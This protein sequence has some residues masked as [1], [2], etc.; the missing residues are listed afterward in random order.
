MLPPRPSEIQNVLIEETPQI[1]THLP[2]ELPQKQLFNGDWVY[3]LG[4]EL[5]DARY[6]AKVLSVKFNETDGET[7]EALKILDE[8][9]PGKHKEA[10]VVPPFYCDYG[11]NIKL[12]RRA[13]L[14]VNTVM[15]DGALISIGDYTKV[16]PNC[17]F[18]TPE[19]PKDPMGR[20]TGLER[21]RPIIIG[22]DVWV[23][24]NV[25]FCPGVTV[26]DNCII[27]AGSVVTRSI[28][29]NTIAVGNP[30]KVL[31]RLYSDGDATVSELVR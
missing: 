26:G 18:N 2:P 29:A 1:K 28:P 12:G 20:R 11:C 23:G 14:N 19:H 9:L 15:L 30:C 5:T 17:S 4:Q 6:R 7:P 8:L 25:A 21:S 10:M 13:F 27:G 24:A 3:P 16:G 31:K 22:N